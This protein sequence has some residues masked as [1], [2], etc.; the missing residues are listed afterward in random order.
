MK[1]T[2]FDRLRSVAAVGAMG[3]GFIAGGSA[4][5]GTN[6]TSTSASFTINN[7]YYSYAFYSTDIYLSSSNTV[8][9]AMGLYYGTMT[10]LSYTTTGSQFV[11]SLT[12]AIYSTLTVALDG[13]GFFDA[14]GTV[15]YTGT[16][17]RLADSN[18]NASGLDLEA[19]Y[20]FF[21]TRQ[22]I[23]L[24]VSLSN[25]TGSPITT[26][27][28]IGGGYTN[29]SDKGTSVVSDSQSGD[30]SFD[31]TDKWYVV[32][33]GVDGN[34]F[35]ANLPVKT[36]GRFGGASR[37]VTPTN[38]VAYPD[39]NPSSY[40]THTDNYNVTVPAGET[41]RILYFYELNTNTAEASAEAATYDSL[42]SLAED[43]FLTGID[44]GQ[45]AQIA[46]YGIIGGPPPP[47]SAP[48]PVPALN[49]WWMYVIMPIVGLFSVRRRQKKHSQ[50]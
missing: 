7:V 43:G 32:H 47:V 40:D 26:D 10:G 30:S 48:L 34:G 44:A 37:S 14:D 42:T 21:T 2:G 24:M 17:Y 20:H 9:A 50:L 19:Q 39:A 45:Q 11:S 1:K 36:L 13:T 28:A 33:N 31:N 6:T 22:A 46:N 38:I 4:R 49:S 12:Y 5:A 27:L 15:D 16:T 3:L 8:E 29:S 25:P 35:A 23:R 18:V 41:V